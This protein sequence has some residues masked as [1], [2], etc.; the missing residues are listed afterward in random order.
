MK[1]LLL[2]YYW[3]PSG[4]SGVQRWMYFC[5]YLHEFGITPIVITVDEKKASYRYIDLAFNDLVKH[6]EVHKTDTF[7]PLRLYSKIISGNQQSAIPIGFAGESRPGFFQKLSRA[8]RGN[9][10]IPDARKG[11]VRFA[12]REARSILKKENIDIIITNGPPHSTHLAALKLKK[13]FNIKW[14]A[15]FRDPWTELYYNKFMYR[16]KCARKRDAKLESAVL[17]NADHLL[18]MGPGMKSHLQQKGDIPAEKISVVYNGFDAE[19]FSKVAISKDKNFFTIT[20]IGMLSGAQPV[21]VFLHALKT[22]FDSNDKICKRIKLQLIGNVSPEI[23]DEVRSTLPELNLEHIAYKPKAEAIRYME[24]ADLLFNSLA[25]MENSELLI[26]GKLME[27]LATGNPIL[28]LGNP[29][30][31][32]AKLLSEFQFSAVFGRADITGITDFLKN[33]FD[34]W[35]KAAIFVKEE[36]KIKQYSRFE[37]T[38]QLADIIKKL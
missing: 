3:P 17:K 31:D 4:G 29:K 34:N 28:C 38:R 15:D 36:N 10:F 8:I 6:V 2:T 27:Y 11:W 7:E 30:G 20:H 22:F 9:F 21:T 23:L 1:V 5:R 25:E 16:S 32:A 12:V 13:E 19:D 26:S 37:T 14:L 35:S 24:S 33:V 18:T